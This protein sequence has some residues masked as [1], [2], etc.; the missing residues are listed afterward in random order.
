MKCHP[1]AEQEEKALG[2]PTKWEALEPEKLSASTQAAKAII[3][4]SINCF[5][6]V[7]HLSNGSC[8]FVSLP[9][10]ISIQVILRTTQLKYFDQWNSI[11][12]QNENVGLECVGTRFKLG[13]N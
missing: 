6:L 9:L 1:R 12:L 4:I 3:T 8:S 7:L 10:Q 2:P 11:C 13:R 5:W